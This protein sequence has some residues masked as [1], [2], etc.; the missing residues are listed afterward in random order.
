MAEHCWHKDH[1]FLDI[2]DVVKCCRC[3]TV[4]MR[5]Q[6]LDLIPGHGPHF[7]DWVPGPTQTK[8]GEPVS[9]ECHPKPK[10]V[11]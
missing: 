8:E 10:E 3:G 4:G 5:G 1:D 9:P 6:V 2:Y 7:L 11:A